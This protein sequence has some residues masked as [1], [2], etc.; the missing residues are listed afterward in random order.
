MNSNDTLSAKNTV[1]HDLNGK[2]VF[3]TG[4]ATGIGASLVRAFYQQGAKV[5]FIDIDEN[6]GFDLKHA[7]ENTQTRHSP[8]FSVVDV[9]DIEVLKASIDNAT[10]QF[11][12]VHA[13]VNNVANDVRH[14]VTDVTPEF[15]Q[16]CMA[17]NMDATF[18]ASQ[19]AFA[20]MKSNGG[21]IVNIG[22]INAILGQ[23]NMPGYVTA[24]S[25]LLGMTKSLARSFGPS[26]VRVNAI[27]PGWV[28]T[29]KQ[30]KLWLTPEEEARWMEQVAIPDRLLP[31]DVANLVVFLASQ[32]SRM[33]TAQNIIIDGGRI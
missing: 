18:F 28:V 22:S 31:E 27:L 8:S 9:T 29:E 7:L 14:E 10:K 21:S 2:H 13:L 24:K 16:K 23:A 26:R 3:I 12:N 33:I 4:G 32:D 6:A 30:L 1:Y 19:H 11:G 17:V 20:S 5:S 15:W 25:A